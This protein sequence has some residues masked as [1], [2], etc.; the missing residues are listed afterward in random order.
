MVVSEK[1]CIFVLAIN[2][3]SLFTMAEIENEIPQ[4]VGKVRHGQV[5]RF[6]GCCTV[7][8][9]GIRFPKAKPVWWDA[10]RLW[11]VAVYMWAEVVDE[12]GMRA[13]L[14]LLVP[15][16]V[17]DDVLRQ[18]GLP[19]LSTPDRVR[20][21][22]NPRWQVYDGEGNTYINR[23]ALLTALNRNSYS[24]MWQCDD[25]NGRLTYGLSINGK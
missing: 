6:T 8:K 1:S 3:I 13:E 2:K 21:S 9:S 4:R 23:L 25:A 16:K 5:E 12:H 18:S 20:H 15:L 24:I 22:I 17:L 14:G 11:H 19:L 10:S 7:I